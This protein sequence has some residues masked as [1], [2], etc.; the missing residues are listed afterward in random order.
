MK[1]RSGVERMFIG[2]A[3]EL[4]PPRKAV[5]KWAYK[6]CFDPVALW[7]KHRARTIRRYGASAADTGSRVTGGS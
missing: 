4:P 7:W 1:P 2:Y 6:H 3:E 5:V